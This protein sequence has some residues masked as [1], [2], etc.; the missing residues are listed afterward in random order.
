MDFTK[1]TNCSDKELYLPDSDCDS[2]TQF[3]LSLNTFSCNNPYDS[4]NNDDILSD[5]DVDTLEDTYLDYDDSDDEDGIGRQLMLKY[6]AKLMD[7]KADV[8]IITRNR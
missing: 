5:S 1:E 2:E 6:K 8:V 4:D 7:S 3:E